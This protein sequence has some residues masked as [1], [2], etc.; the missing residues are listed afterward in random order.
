MH[1]YKPAYY[2]NTAAEAVQ[3]DAVMRQGCH[4]AQNA[5]VVHTWGSSKEHKETAD[6]AVQ[7]DAVMRQG[8]PPQ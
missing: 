5:R 6:A 8:C 1:T 3:I 7:G 4:S 2:N